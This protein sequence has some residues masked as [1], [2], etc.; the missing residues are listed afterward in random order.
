MSRHSEATADL[1]RQSEAAAEAIHSPSIG[2]R[3]SSDGHRPPLQD[4]HPPPSPSHPNPGQSRQ[5]KA[6]KWVFVPSWQKMAA[7]KGSA[8]N[9]AWG[10][11]HSADATT[12]AGPSSFAGA[13]DDGTAG[14]QSAMNSSR[15]KTQE[16]K[17]SG[18]DHRET[19][20][21]REN[22]V[23]FVRVFRVVLFLFVGYV[24]K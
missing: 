19:R 13:A 22:R 9:P 15:Q 7:S 1:S 20:E 3:Q 14:R 12:F 21:I 17:K 2:V 5:I 11:A 8:R 10:S 6:K 23:A 18:V 4:W 16:R 24:L